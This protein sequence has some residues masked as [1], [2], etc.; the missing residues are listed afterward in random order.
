[1]A[2]AGLRGTGS[3]GTGERPKSFRE[4]ILWEEPNGQSPLTALM[5]KMRSE[6]LSD[7]EFNWWQERQQAVRIQVNGALSNV[8]TTA[9][10]DAVD[11]THTTDAS[12]LVPGDIL[13]VESAN[14]VITGERVLV[15]TVV[16]ATSFTITRGAAGTTGAAIADNS[17]L[18]RV[19]SV[20][21]EGSG[22][23][24][25]V[26]TNPIKMYNLAQIF[27]TSY[28]VTKTDI[29]TTHRTGDPLKNERKRKMFNHA[30]NME[31]AYLF[32]LKFETVGANG[33]PMRMT[34]G[35]VSQLSTNVKAY[36]IVSAQFNV[37][38]WIADVTRVFDYDAGGAGNERLVLLGNGALQE[39]QKACEAKSNVRINFEGGIKIYGMD[40]QKVTTPQGTFYFKTHPLFNTHPVHR[41]SM[42][43]LNPKGLV[44]RFLRK[45]TFEDNIQAPGSDFVKGQWLTESGPEVQFEGSHAF[46]SNC[47]YAA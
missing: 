36:D 6:K 13:M 23:A 18:L 20:F 39:L 8:A 47:I 37:D 30:V 12:N 24:G 43:V 11:A 46:Y 41:Y 3:Y 28:E 17:W 4:L 14:G 19:G 15:A 45:T 7:P 16:S 1:M 25:A 31:L 33:Q 40:F 29:E 21:A 44:D 27:K 9:V 38:N 5:A 2:F 34:G 10:V 35:I 26:S 42:V 32:G 22:A